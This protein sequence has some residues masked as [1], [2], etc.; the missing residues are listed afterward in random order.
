MPLSPGIFLGPYEVLAPPGAGG[1]GDV[2]RARDTRL[3]REVALKILPQ[4]VADNA[5]RQARFEQEARE[6]AVLNHP[7]IVA[8]YDVGDGYMVSEIKIGPNA[9]GKDG[10]ILMPVGSTIQY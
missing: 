2:Y 10:R 6:V 3:G 9:I 4:E 1:M 5:S 8:V 7:D